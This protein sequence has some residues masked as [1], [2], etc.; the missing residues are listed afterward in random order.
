VEDG[1]LEAG[2]GGRHPDD[3]LLVPP[4]GVL[5]VVVVDA[6]GALGAVVDPEHDVG[7]EV[8]VAPVDVLEVLPRAHGNL[9]LVA[10]THGSLIPFGRNPWQTHASF[11]PFASWI[12]IREREWEGLNRRVR[13]LRVY[14]YL[15]FY[16]LQ[17]FKLLTFYEL[18]IVVI[19]QLAYS[20]VFHML[21]R[22]KR[23]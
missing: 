19:M 2:G 20:L 22:N 1:V 8:A 10:G 7:L 17:R 14:A 23:T 15:L 13:M 3:E 9:H 18:F 11:L 12:A 4:F 21:G 6:G 16:A 5:A